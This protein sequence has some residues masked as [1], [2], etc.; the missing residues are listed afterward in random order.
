[1]MFPKFENG[2]EIG[3]EKILAKY[4][5]HPECRILEPKIIFF[6]KKKPIIA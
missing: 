4:P 5:K 2:F 3:V 6:E 1:M